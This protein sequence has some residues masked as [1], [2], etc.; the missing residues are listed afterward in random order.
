MHSTNYTNTLISPSEDTTAK[1]GTVPVKAESVAGLQYQLL[2]EASYTLTGD[3][4][5]VAVT[6]M[7]RGVPAD[8]QNALREE[9]FRKGQPC[10]RTSPLVKTHGWAVHYNKDGRIALVGCETATYRALSTAPDITQVKGMRS[11]RA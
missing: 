3:D 8:E 7:R 4:V 10:L 6:A 11:K 2:S 1:A 9:L 5:L